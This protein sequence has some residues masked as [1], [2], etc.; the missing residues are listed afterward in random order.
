LSVPLPSLLTHRKFLRAT[1]NVG[2]G[3]ATNALLGSSR[4]RAADGKTIK[5]GILH[6]LTRWFGPQETPLRD[7]ELLAIEEINNAGGVLGKKIEAVVED[8]ES[9][10]T[11]IYPIKAK[12]LLVED[13]VA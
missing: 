5:V 9:D 7:A 1:S 4:V 2:L 11:E 3:L 8:P 12:K 13:K 10:F 6:S